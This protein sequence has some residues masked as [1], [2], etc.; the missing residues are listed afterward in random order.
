MTPKL[1]CRLGKTTRAKTIDGSP[2]VYTVEEEDV[3]IAPSNVEKAYCLQKLR[4]D[5]GTV[6]YRICYYM[7]A[8]KP[9]MKG[10]W[11]FGQFAPMMTSEE[12]CLI[13]E[14]AKAKGWV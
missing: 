14:K 1:P 4:L 9:R 2:L 12:M 5:D 7:I 8:K 6:G 13:F 3:F 10:K 11:A